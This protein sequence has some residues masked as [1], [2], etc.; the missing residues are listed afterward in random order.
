MKLKIYESVETI[1]EMPDKELNEDYSNDEI[2]YEFLESVKNGKGKVLYE[3]RNYS[4]DNYDQEC[5]SW[6]TDV[7][8]YDK[9]TKQRKRVEIEEYIKES[10]NDK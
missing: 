2:A 4:S 3:D 7:W 5:I 10:D 1:I 9:E 8:V 6:D